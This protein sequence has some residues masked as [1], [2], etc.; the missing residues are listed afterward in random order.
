MD[1]MVSI[2]APV[3]G[4]LP[5]ISRGTGSAGFNPRPCEGATAQPYSFAVYPFWALFSSILL[6]CSKFVAY[7]YTIFI[8]TYKFIMLKR[9]E[10]TGKCCAL[11]IPAAGY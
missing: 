9:R 8:K 7:V 5:Q 10:R 3:K 11:M 4:R 2:H 6:L 1:G